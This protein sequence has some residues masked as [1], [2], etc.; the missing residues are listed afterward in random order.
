[1]AEV[2]AVVVSRPEKNSAKVSAFMDK[3]YGI[4]RLGGVSLLDDPLQVQLSHFRL[5]LGERFF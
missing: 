2:T 4:A 1:M 3:A 5:H